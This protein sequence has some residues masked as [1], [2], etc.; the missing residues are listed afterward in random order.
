MKD[1]SPASAAPIQKLLGA[2]G[3]LFAEIHQRIA[4]I[5]TIQQ[6]LKSILP[7]PL[8]DH[9]VVANISRATL[10]LHTDSPAWAAK[11]RFSTPEILRCV[12]KPG[13]TQSDSPKSL[14][15]KVVPVSPKADLPRE[16][17]RL[18]ATNRLLIK[19]TANSISDPALRA[20]L[21]RLSQN[22]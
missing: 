1:T 8:C 21:L 15:I 22:Q 2:Q 19:Q 12:Q 14:R 6:K 18:S 11:L 16:K 13:T 10:V 17:I 3:T 9:F 20:A 7:P 4:H 5:Q